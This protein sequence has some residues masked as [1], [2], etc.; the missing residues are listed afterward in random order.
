VSENPS[1]TGWSGSF[2]GLT[3]A[4]INTIKYGSMNYYD[5]G[6]GTEYIYMSVYDD[7]SRSSSNPTP[8][9]KISVVSVGG[10]TLNLSSGI[11]NVYGV[12]S[13]SPN[14]SGYP[15]FTVATKNSGLTL[16]YG[17]SIS[18][19]YS[20]SVII[21]NNPGSGQSNSLTTKYYS[22]SNYTYS[23]SVHVAYQSADGK[24]KYT[25]VPTYNSSSNIVSIPLDEEGYTG[26]STSIDLNSSQQ[27]NITYLNKE[28]I[29]SKEALRYAVYVGSSVNASS[30]GNRA[31]WRYMIIPS[32]VIVND[33]KTKVKV[34][35][36]P[37]STNG[38]LVVGYRGADYIYVSR[39]Y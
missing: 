5:T 16:G 13:I 30:L 33:E 21:D 25:Y 3:Y 20:S 14:S 11:N 17:T 24:L 1:G 31:N 15:V 2:R 29:N 35:R 12:T 6:S 34:P 26:A 36:S 7:D 19:S 8:S 32:D 22:G 27:P 18:S 28:K 39:L 4:D 38:N 9:I 37:N 10:T 23:N